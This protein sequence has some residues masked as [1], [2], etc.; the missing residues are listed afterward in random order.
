MLW[1]GNIVSVARLTGLFPEQTPCGKWTIDVVLVSVLRVNVWD[2]AV[3]TPAQLQL[4]LHYQ[5]TV[6]IRLL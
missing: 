1:G 6:T 5:M 3:S 2:V 4:G